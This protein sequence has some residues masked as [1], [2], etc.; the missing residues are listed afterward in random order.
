MTLWGAAELAIKA[1]GGGATPKLA[2]VVLEGLEL[3]SFVNGRMNWT[4]ETSRY[5]GY[6]QKLIDQLEAGK[7]IKRSD[8]LA[9]EPGAERDRQFQL[10]TRSYCWL[11]WLH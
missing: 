1:L 9:G 5:A 3:G 4:I 8:L 6:F 2:Q 11:F 10:R 7:V